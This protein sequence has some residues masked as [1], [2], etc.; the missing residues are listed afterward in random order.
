MSEGPGAQE[1]A[2]QA[3]PALARNLLLGGGWESGV[4]DGAGL[5]AAGARQEWVWEVVVERAMVTGRDCV[6]MMI[7]G[8]W[9]HRGGEH[10]RGRLP[11]SSAEGDVNTVKGVRLEATY[12]AI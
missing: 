10:S 11:H 8:I 6:R 3:M 12:R 1:E 7:Q 4:M 5:R 2:V 9:S